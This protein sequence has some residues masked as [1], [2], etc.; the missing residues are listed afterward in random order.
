MLTEVLPAALR[1]DLETIRAA[2]L[3]RTPTGR[4]ANMTRKRR[5]AAGQHRIAMRFVPQ[6]SLAIT[7][8]WSLSSSERLLLSYLLSLPRDHR[9]ISEISAGSI[10]SA[11]GHSTR[12]AHRWLQG[13]QEYGYLH[14]RAGRTRGSLVITLTAKAVRVRQLG[15]GDIAAAEKKKNP[16][17]LPPSGPSAPIS[18]PSKREVK[19]EEEDP[20]EA[21]LKRLARRLE[22]ARGTPMATYWQRMYA[23]ALAREGHAGRKARGSDAMPGK[24]RR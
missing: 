6:H 7:L 9:T 12:S 3:G 18:A 24:Q 11:F 23:E 10:A 19:K 21:M 22:A 4:P 15:P 17:A 1:A 16:P 5:S 13:L 20:G 14:V 2:G 8:D